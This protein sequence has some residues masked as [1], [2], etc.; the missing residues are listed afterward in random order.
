M[1]G[2]ANVYIA[3][4]NRRWM[5]DMRRAGEVAERER[6]EEEQADGGSTE[7]YPEPGR[8]SRFATQGIISKQISS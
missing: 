5:K 8:L 1:I 2:T 3:F 6:E 4:D 7:P